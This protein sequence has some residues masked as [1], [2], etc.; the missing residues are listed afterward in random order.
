MR[1]RKTFTFR[2]GSHSGAA[3]AGGPEPSGE[4]LLQHFRPAGDRYRRRLAWFVLCALAGFLLSLVSILV[5][6][7]LLK[8]FAIPGIALIALSLVLFFTLPAPQCP[9]CG[10]ATD[11]GFD[12]FCPVCGKEALRISRLWGTRCDACGRGM[13]SYKYRN[14]RIRYCTHCGILLD[15]RGI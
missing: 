9:A 13:G 10:K 8:W 2:I 11:N 7:F 14:Y 6:G 1:I 3:G 12:R 5:P 4:E 15:T